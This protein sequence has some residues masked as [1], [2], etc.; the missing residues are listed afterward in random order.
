MDA[1][2]SRRVVRGADDLQRPRIFDFPSER[3]RNA[4]MVSIDGRADRIY[5]IWIAMLTPEHPEAASTQEQIPIVGHHCEPA[6]H[7]P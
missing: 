1:V 7:V 5:R 6:F 3:E 4:C 2:M